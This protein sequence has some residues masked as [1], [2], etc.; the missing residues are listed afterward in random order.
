MPPALADG[1]CKLLLN[2]AL[3][4]LQLILIKHLIQINYKEHETN[5]RFFF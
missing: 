3:A 2:W 1:L 4:T 5:K